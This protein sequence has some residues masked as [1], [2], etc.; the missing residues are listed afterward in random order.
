MSVRSCRPTLFTVPPA[1]LLAV[2]LAGCGAAPSA[3]PAS[4]GPVTSV[5]Q[6]AVVTTTDRRT[7]GQENS[8]TQSLTY[9]KPITALDIR[10]AAGDV[11]VTGDAPDDTVRIVRHRS[12]RGAE[13]V[14]ADTWSGTSLATRVTCDSCGVSF[15]LHVPAAVA[16]TLATDSGDVTSTGLRGD[17]ALSSSS[18]D[19]TARDLSAGTVTAQTSSGTV[20]LDLATAPT[21]VTA[22][23]SAGDVTV[24]VPGG[25]GYRVEATTSAG[26][27]EIGVP[28]DPAATR[29]ITARTEAGDVTVRAR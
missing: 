2:A 22:T 28:D 3:A 10:T 27:R 17:A 14:V 1:V 7:D 18:G 21:A 16:A 5:V 25:T 24:A 11:A 19:V 8:D 4:S 9:R 26:D 20:D 13:P 12:W 6:D 29:T 15:E 23:S